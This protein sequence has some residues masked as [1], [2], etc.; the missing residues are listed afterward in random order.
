MSAA[1][2]FQT[3]PSNGAA[4]IGTPQKYIWDK[5]T[6]KAECPQLSALGAHAGPMLYTCGAEAQQNEFLPKIREERMIWCQG[7]SEP[8]GSDLL[9]SMPPSGRGMNTWSTAPSSGPRRPCGGLDVLP[10][11]HGKR[12]EEA[13]G[14][15]FV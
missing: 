8:R 9:A 13:G 11:A 1:G 15:S 2:P 4:R 14:I 5:E 12:R 7:Y 6:A 10:G 3:G